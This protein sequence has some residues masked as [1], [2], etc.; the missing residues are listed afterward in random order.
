MY[1]YELHGYTV[2]CA[3]PLPMGSTEAVSKKADLFITYSNIKIKEPPSMHPLRSSE[4][5]EVAWLGSCDLG[6]ILNFQNQ[7]QFLFSENIL[8]VLN[9]SLS[10]SDL[11]TLLLSQVIPMA[12]SF[13]AD[14]MLHASGIEKF[15]QAWAFLGL[16]GAGKSTLAASFLQKDFKVLSDDS[17]RVDISLD[18]IKVY[19]GTPEIRMFSESIGKIFKNPEAL[20]FS[21]AIHKM[22]IELPNSLP[23][24][25]PL[26]GL[27]CLNPQVEDTEVSVNFL[28]PKE[29]LPYLLRSLFRWDLQSQRAMTKEISGAV[30]LLSQTPAYLV[31]YSHKWDSREILINKI[32]EVMLL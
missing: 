13:K 25:L 19:P 22:R 32:S 3:W 30:N 24:A 9:T 23:R 5:H 15:G 21:K 6:F 20:N 18:P 14:L 8:S 7:A 12:F 28:K 26:A 16:E 11:D 2:E 4:G 27:F 10:E 1:S 31:N 17:L 29:A